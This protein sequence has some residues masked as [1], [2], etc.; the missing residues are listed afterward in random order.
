MDATPDRLPDELTVTR[1]LPVVSDLPPDPSPDEQAAAAGLVH[2]SDDEPG[3]AR[4]PWG[5][6]F[7]F[8]FPDGRTIPRSHPQRRRAEALAVPP[9][10]T[11]VWV[12]RDPSGHIQATGRDDAGRK[13]YLYHPRWRGIRDATKFHRL[14]AFSDAL[15][16]IR[17]TVDARLRQPRF[18]VDR[19]L[20]LALALLDE[21]LIRVG[22]GQYTRDHGTVG[23][24]TLEEEHV[25]VDGSHVRFSFT[26]KSGS[27]RDVEVRHPR[28][29]RQLLRCEEI[30]GQRLF[31][32]QDASGWHEVDSAHVNDYL[33]DVAGDAVTAKDFRTWG[34]TVRVAHH[35]HE[36]GPAES[37][38]DADDRVLDAI[39]EAADCLGNSR[40]VARDSYVDPRVT[41]TYRHGGLDDAW[42]QVHEERHRLSPAERAVRRILHGA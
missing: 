4:L 30:P 32:Y 24:T 1:A 29:A 28:L 35:L 13:Q 22:N 42:D 37:A 36:V 6:G 19:M 34:A 21:T 31:S 27:E 8:R 3:L 20:A 9:A 41:A 12:C 17:A 23:V 5:T 39:D 11:D 7:T 40:A 16:R 18:T 38:R 26:G 33:A 25:E 15:P 10:W 14:G 2:V